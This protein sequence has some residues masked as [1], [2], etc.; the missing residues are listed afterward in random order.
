MKRWR[1]SVAFLF[2]ARKTRKRKRRRTAVVPRAAGRGGVRR[3][4]ASRGVGALVPARGACPREGRA[5]GDEG[6][7]AALG[8]GAGGAG[9][10]RGPRWGQIGRASCRERV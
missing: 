8:G 10:D 5:R 1:C 9:E 3:T 4:R 2:L 6:P 7:E